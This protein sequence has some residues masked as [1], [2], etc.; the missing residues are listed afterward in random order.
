MEIKISRL[1]RAYVGGAHVGRNQWQPLR[2][3]LMSSTHPIFDLPG[4]IED[5]PDDP[6]YEVPRCPP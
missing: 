1:Y 3:A 4:M 2:F 6:P 5:V